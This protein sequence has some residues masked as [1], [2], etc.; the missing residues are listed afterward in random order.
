MAGQRP[1][2]H[3]ALPRTHPELADTNVTDSG[4]K[5]AGNRPSAR[6]DGVGAGVG[7]ATATG[8]VAGAGE[9]TATGDVVGEPVDGAVALGG[10]ATD[11]EPPGSGP[12]GRPQ[13]DRRRGH[14]DDRRDRGEPRHMPRDPTNPPAGGSGEPHQRRP[15]CPLRGRP[16]APGRARGPSPR[17]SPDLALERLVAVH[18]SGLPS[19]L[20]STAER[21]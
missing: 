7:V 4:R 6:A 20:G 1:A 18:R 12:Y 2:S 15:G 8:E 3:G 11:G 5:P 17:G 10:T 14:G 16:G 19:R 13:E 9:P 21:R